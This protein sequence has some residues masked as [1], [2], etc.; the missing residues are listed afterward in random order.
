LEVGAATREARE[1]R[2]ARGEAG[3]AL[4][5]S[6]LRSNQPRSAGA[7]KT[8]AGTYASLL[9]DSLIRSTLYIR[10]QAARECIAAR[11]STSAPLR[12]NP[13]AMVS[14]ARW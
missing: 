2:A 13:V 8:C 11:I 5:R 10:T 4:P 9:T 6:V 1:R 12:A 7:A 14:R 3:F